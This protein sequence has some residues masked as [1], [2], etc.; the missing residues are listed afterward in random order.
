[1]SSKNV[2]VKKLGEIF[3]GEGH[4]VFDEKDDLGVRFSGTAEVCTR[5]LRRMVLSAFFRL[6][7]LKQNA[8]SLPIGT[9]SYLIWR[10]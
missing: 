6:A 7:R 8:L 5:N 2:S 1:M 10:N 9:P 3:V 4:E